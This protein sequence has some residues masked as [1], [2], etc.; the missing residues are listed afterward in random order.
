MGHLAIIFT[1]NKSITIRQNL[2]Y[3][4]NNNIKING[5]FKIL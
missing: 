2:K 4:N 3:K 5:C 1:R